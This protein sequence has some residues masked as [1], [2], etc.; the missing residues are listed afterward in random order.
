METVYLGKITMSPTAY[1]QASKP[2]RIMEFTR[3]AVQEILPE[4]ETL[5]QFIHLL[6]QDLKK[7][8]EI[9]YRVTL[10]DE[11]RQPITYLTSQDKLGVHL[12]TEFGQHFYSVQVH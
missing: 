10:V 3:E 12:D 9:E 2:E 6:R 8:F 4:C 11:Y 1:L 5:D 7:N